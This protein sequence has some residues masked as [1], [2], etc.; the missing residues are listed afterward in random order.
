MRKGLVIFFIVFM[1]CCSILYSNNAYA[2]DKVVV[3]GNTIWVSG[4]SRLTLENPSVFHPYLKITS[5]TAADL[6]WIETT[7][8]L[9]LGSKI[10]GIL[11][12]YQTPDTG[13]FISQMRLSEY[14]LPST[15]TVRYD[16]PS[17][18][19]DSNGNC[20]ISSVTPDYTPYGSVNLS[21][22]LNF[23][24]LFDEP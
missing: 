12:C 8:P 10:K 2:T 5:D 19:F 1:F 9:T 6:Q 13:T 4:D 14:I 20:Y 11:L 23:A 7:I 3:L 16:D 17:D 21:L 18:L 22:R 15:A 24:V